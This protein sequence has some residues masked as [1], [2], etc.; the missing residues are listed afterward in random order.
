MGL[1][2]KV[3]EEKFVVRFRLKITRAKKRTQ[4][5]SW[6]WVIHLRNIVRN[7]SG[8]QTNCTPSRKVRVEIGVFFYVC[9]KPK[10]GALN[11]WKMTKRKYK[12][13]TRKN[14]FFIYFS[15]RPCLQRDAF[16]ASTSV[17]QNICACNK[18]KSRKSF[19]V[20]AFVSIRASAANQADCEK[21][22]SVKKGRVAPPKITACKKKTLF[23]PH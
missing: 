6:V 2:F 19:T 18:R 8:S 16:I 4:R 12:M 13:M 1:R 7:Y 22:L 17:S 10:R 5:K 20:D 15:H 21:S 11:I 23:E 14:A 3:S 9:T